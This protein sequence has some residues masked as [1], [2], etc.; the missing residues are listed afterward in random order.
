[1]QRVEYRISCGCGTDGR[2]CFTSCDL[3]VLAV[4]TKHVKLLAADPTKVFVERRTVTTSEWIAL[5]AV[6]DRQRSEG[7]EPADD[8]GF[9]AN[10]IVP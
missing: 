8:F 7:A 5:L 2:H 1:M 6:P 9:V 4:T 10:D 3:A